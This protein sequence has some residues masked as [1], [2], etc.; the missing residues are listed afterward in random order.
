MKA[1]QSPLFRKT[2][3]PWY[4]TEAS[5]VVVLIMM[6][7]VLLFSLS[8]IGVVHSYPEYRSHLWVPLGLIGMS[9]FVILSTA[10]RLVRRKFSQ[11][12]DRL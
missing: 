5:C 8:G 3:S 2:I 12:G 4:D 10:I 9:L 11:R 6:V 7:M 1:D